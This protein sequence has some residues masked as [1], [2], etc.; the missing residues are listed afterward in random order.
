[1][2]RDDDQHGAIEYNCATLY[3]SSYI[4]SHLSVSNERPASRI[5]QIKI[6]EV[7]DELERYTVNGWTPISIFSVKK[8][9]ISNFGF[10]YLSF[11]RA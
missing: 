6:D 9:A 3:W 2:L 10:T 4:L 8:D 1:M 5:N 11:G 7:T